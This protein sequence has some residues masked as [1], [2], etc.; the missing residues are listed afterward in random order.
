MTIKAL[1][2]KVKEVAVVDLCDENRIPYLKCIQ[3]LITGKKVFQKG[4][5]PDKFAGWNYEQCMEWNNTIIFKPTHLNI[6]LGNSEEV[7]KYCVVDLDDKSDLPYLEVLGNDWM[8][9]SSQRQ[10]PHLWRLRK[11]ND[12]SR[13]ATKITINGVKTSI[14]IKYANIIEKI[15][16]KIQ[17]INGD[18]PP[19]FDF[20]RFHP[21]P[22]GEK[23]QPRT[24]TEPS[25]QYKRLMNNYTGKRFT[26]HLQNIDHTQYTNSY[27]DWLKIGFAIKR[28]FSNAD[29]PNLWF[30]ILVAY[31][32]LSPNHKSENTEQWLTMFEADSKCGIPTIL[33]YS[34]KSNETNFN[35]IETEYFKSRRA[36]ETDEQSSLLNA[37]YKLLFDS[38]KSFDVKQEEKITKLKYIIKDDYDACKI[39]KDI[40]EKNIVR[41][42]DMWYV[43]NP[44]TTYWNRGEEFVKQLILKSGFKK[45]TALGPMPYSANATG[46][47]NIFKTMLSSHDLFTINENFINEINE[48]TRGRLYFEDKY[49]DFV[50]KEWQPITDVIPLVYI[51]RK[52]PTFNFTPEEIAEFK[53]KVLNMFATDDDRNLYLHALSRALAGYTEDKK[54]YV[55]KGMR[56]SGKGVLQEQSFSSFGEFCCIYDAPMSKSNNK[57]DASDRRWVLAIN[58]HIKR[59]AF[60]NE[61][62]DV[63]GKID[64]TLDGNELKK[65]ICSGGDG[66][67]ARGHYKDEITIKNNT[68][69]FMSLNDVPRAKPADALEN[70][71]LFDMPFKFVD[72]DQVA[73]DIKYREADYSL[74]ARIKKDEKWRDIFL[75]L[76]FEGFKPEAIQMSQMNEINQAEAM[77][78]RKEGDKNDYIKIFNATFV[79]DEI[80]W[81]S[82]DDI[83]KILPKN[84]LSDVKFSYFLKDRGFIQKRGNP[85]PMKDEHGNEMKDENGKVKTKQPQGYSGL[86]FKTMEETD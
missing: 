65:V 47:S 26:D 86:S 22:I 50:K 24:P 64:L 75:H 17:F 59:V 71:I 56:N 5:I 6:L 45:N 40:Y 28:I 82:T 80:G 39:M 36:D 14:D 43:N 51:K 49:W 63:A 10:L 74:K 53:A 85:V 68:T 46:C 1:K 18:F 70:M 27:C 48:N 2:P 52:A 8:S 23:P 69:T 58:A 31:S 41:A 44:N 30:E 79:K 76:L 34:Q 19:E 54:F 21:R 37:G 84:K 78:V 32:E 11:E 83:R 42:S 25:N 60:T 4:T 61:T 33:E 81:V 62:S 29:E 55:M 77:E 12:F 72:K 38:V 57:G 35:S 7:D 16:S 66:F 3:K 73:N 15:D 20:E 67:M 13:C 9:K